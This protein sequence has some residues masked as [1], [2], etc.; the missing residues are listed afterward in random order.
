MSHEPT[1]IVRK[2]IP[3]KIRFEVFKRDKF[4]CQYCGAA[5]PDVVLNCDHV[6]PV[7]LG[8]DPDVLNL[9]LKRSMTSSIFKGRMTCGS[10][11]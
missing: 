10:K 2:P 6:K 4:T 7:A 3:N 11:R 8:G 5:A 1:P 9:P